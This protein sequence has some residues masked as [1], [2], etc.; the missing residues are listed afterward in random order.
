MT[1]YHGL[2]AS[3]CC[4]RLSLRVC[5]CVCVCRCLRLTKVLVFH[6]PPPPGQ[7][8]R[9]RQIV[10]LKKRFNAYLYLD[11]AHSIGAVGPRGRGVTDH[12]GVPT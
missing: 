2:A 10:A 11:E 7:F 8:A 9:L 6:P 1:T 12:L 3:C 5:V 4:R